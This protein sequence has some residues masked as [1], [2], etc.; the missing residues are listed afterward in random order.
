MSNTPAQQFQAI[1]DAARAEPYVLG[2]FL[3]G[4]RGKGFE[5][6]F[7][8]YDICLILQDA[9]PE[10]V[11]ERYW[12][13]NSAA[14]DL[15]GYTLSE[16]PNQ[17][18]WDGPE[19]WD[20]Y[21]YTHVTALIDKCDG[22]IQ[23]LIDE[24]G[25]IST[26]RRS[27]WIKGQLDAYINSLYRS[28]KCI[29]KG[30]LRGA[31]LEAHESIGWLLDVLFGYEGR[32]RPYYGYLERELGKYPL[33]SIPLSSDALLAKIDAI[34]ASADRATQQELLTMVDALLRPDGFGEVFDS[35]DADYQ[36]MHS[37]KG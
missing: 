2:L 21:S 6:E 11:R 15:W 8:D 1:F 34:A 29:R 19:A 36:W 3:G 17:A 33:T 23:R 35:W 22:Q 4:S 13:W 10:P 27:A 16:F 28:L 9:T 32:H 37:F 5:N 14:I 24:K 25:T 20:R 18:A 7:S 30:N 26:E 12:Q 31:R